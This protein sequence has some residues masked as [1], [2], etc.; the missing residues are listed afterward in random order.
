[1]RHKHWTEES[2]A[3]FA[4]RIASDFVEQLEQKRKLAQ[5]AFGA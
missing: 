1:M 3:A 2:T 5:E 4:Y